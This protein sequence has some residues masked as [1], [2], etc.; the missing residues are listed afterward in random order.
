MYRFDWESPAFGGTLGAAHAMDIPFVWNTLDTTLSRTFTGDSPARQPLADLMHAAWAAFIRGGTPAIA[1]LPAW[2]P[3]D[4]ER[5]ATMIF[6][7]APHV[8]DNPQG[9]VR[10]LWK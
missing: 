6:S 7:A 3:Y 10:A 8:V 9:Q 4:L 2:P 1:G 5:R